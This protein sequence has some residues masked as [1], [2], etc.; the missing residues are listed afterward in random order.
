MADF[1]SGHLRSRLTA[2]VP[3]QHQP[4]VFSKF[5][6]IQAANLAIFASVAVSVLARFG[7]V[8]EESLLLDLLTAAVALG[9]A[10]YSFYHRHQKGDLTPE[11]FRRDS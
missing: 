3:P 1:T 7:I 9:A 8:V 2:K 6:N 10:L 11:G 4:P 5:S